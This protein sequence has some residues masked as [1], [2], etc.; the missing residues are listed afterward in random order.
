MQ[1]VTSTQHINKDMLILYTNMGMLIYQHDHSPTQ[2]KSWLL[3]G[4]K[5][6]LNEPKQDCLIVFEV[7]GWVGWLYWL[8]IVQYVLT[9]YSVMCSTKWEWKW[10]WFD[11]DWWI[12]M[13]RSWQIWSI[14][15]D[16][17]SIPDDFSLTDISWVSHTVLISDQ[18]IELNK[19]P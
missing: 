10:E 16:D 12:W 2:S 11:D 9:P 19:A 4:D 1:D 3:F 15:D 8:C 17:F 14:S 13:W 6:G 5:A 18:F 7:G